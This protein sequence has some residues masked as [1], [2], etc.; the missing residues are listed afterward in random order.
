MELGGSLLFITNQFVWAVAL[1]WI[2]FTV[3]ASF[4][5]PLHLLR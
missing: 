5:L 4:F 2:V 1:V 3:S